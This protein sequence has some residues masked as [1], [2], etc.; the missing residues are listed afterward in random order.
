MFRI[1]IGIDI[2]PQSQALGQKRVHYCHG[3]APV[4][5]KTNPLADPLANQ[6][7]KTVSPVDFLK[8]V[9]LTLAKIYTKKMP[10]VWYTDCCA[11]LY[12]TLC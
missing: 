10:F 12:I 9:V 4:N 3:L 11:F 6:W 8:S 5:H 2:I 7:Q 1:C